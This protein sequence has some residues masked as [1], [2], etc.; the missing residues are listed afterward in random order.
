MYAATIKRPT[1]ASEAPPH[2]APLA[3]PLRQIPSRLCVSNISGVR[4]QRPRPG[5]TLRVRAQR[6]EEGREPPARRRRRAE[7]GAQPRRASAAYRRLLCGRLP[8]EH[9]EAMFEKPVGAGWRSFYPPALR[10]GKM[11]AATIKRPTPTS[12][13]PPHGAA[14]A[15]PSRATPSFALRSWL[16][17]HNRTARSNLFKSLQGVHMWTPLSHPPNPLTST[18][19]YRPARAPCAR[20]APR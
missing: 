3:L 18:P 4:G 19:R 5:P 6:A 10:R 20:P 15:L 14:L 17:P 7:Q 12:E 9:C 13:A 2:G 16:R 8:A 11:Y 1:P